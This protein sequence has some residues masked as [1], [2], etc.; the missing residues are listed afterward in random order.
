MAPT[1]IGET[2]FFFLIGFLTDIWVLF[3]IQYT[4]LICCVCPKVPKLKDRDNEHTNLYHCVSKAVPNRQWAQ[5][6]FIK[7]NISPS[8]HYFLFVFWQILFG[9]TVFAFAL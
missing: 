6:I 5:K 8:D 9:V 7:V 4:L 1:F 3:L 2:T